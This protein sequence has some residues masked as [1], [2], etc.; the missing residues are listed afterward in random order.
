LKEEEEEGAACAA[1]LSGK[2][3]YSNGE[4]RRFFADGCAAAP[5]HF[6][7]WRPARLKRGNA[8]VRT[9]N[10][11]LPLPLPPSI[12][13]ISL[14]MMINAADELSSMS[15]L[16]DRQTRRG[17]ARQAAAGQAGGAILRLLTFLQHC[18]CIH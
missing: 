6:D 14:F 10:I 9:E 8:A 7:S 4:K 18:S 3:P 11:Q 5:P 16:S 1:Y 12:N 15:T 13:T 2:A 17:A